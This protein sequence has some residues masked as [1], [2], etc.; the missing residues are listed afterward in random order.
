MIGSC[1]EM[2]TIVPRIQEVSIFVPEALLDD[3]V[4]PERR[5]LPGTKLS[6]SS[7]GS[8]LVRSHRS[9]SLTGSSYHVRCSRTQLGFLVRLSNA[10]TNPSKNR[11]FC[12]PNPEV[13]APVL[14]A[15][16]CVLAWQKEDRIL[17]QDGRM[18]LLV[19]AP[20]VESVPQ[21]GELRP[22]CALPG[23]KGT[24]VHRSEW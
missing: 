14:Q 22:V 21:V 9:P 16:G 15:V 4:L 1:C 24:R 19:L 11:I 5:S 7:K 12:N 18:L 23:L 8:R 6:H 13:G 17:A 20:L 10:A 2:S 3:R